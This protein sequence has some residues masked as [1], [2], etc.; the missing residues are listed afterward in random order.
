MLAMARGL[1]HALRD[2]LSPAAASPFFDGAFP[3]EGAVALAARLQWRAAALR[4]A[5]A[6]RLPQLYAARPQLVLYGLGVLGGLVVLAALLCV[7]R[8]LRGACSALALATGLEAF[9]GLA[10]DEGAPDELIDN[11]FWAGTHSRR[12]EAEAAAREGKEE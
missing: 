3:S 5:A 1:A 4:W 2:L 11:P 10:E 6:L 9:R 7:H 12:R 8:A